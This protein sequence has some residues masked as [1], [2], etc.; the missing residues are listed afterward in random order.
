MQRLFTIFLTAT[1]LVHATLGCCVHHAHSWQVGCGETRAMG[2][3][4]SPCSGHDGHEQHRTPTG[5][6][7]LNQP[8]HR[9]QP[10]P[11]DGPHRCEDDKCIFART[12]SSPGADSL[13]GG[14]FLDV[15]ALPA[16]SIAYI[17]DSPVAATSFKPVAVSG[18]PRWHLVLAVL[19]I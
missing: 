7:W 8:D 16:I 11:H 3:G 1:V 2:V 10:Q 15:L 19:L 5:A 4:S 18:T 17:A 14:E 12:E 13:N 6:I 9:D